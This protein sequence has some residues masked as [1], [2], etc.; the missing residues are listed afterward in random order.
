M[1]PFFK[2]RRRIRLRE[3]PFPDEWR[4]TIERNVPIV[5]RLPPAD[6]RELFGHVQVFLA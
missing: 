1:T 5:R 3:Q 2:S 4:R 6:V